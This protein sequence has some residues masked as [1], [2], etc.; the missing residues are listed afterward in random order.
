M[1]L[2]QSHFLALTHQQEQ[3]RRQLAES[4]HKLGQRLSSSLAQ[5]FGQLQVSA[6]E[7]RTP[8]TIIKGFTQVLRTNPS[9]AE[10]GDA[11]EMMAGSLSRVGRLHEVVTGRQAGGGQPPGVGHHRRGQHLA[12]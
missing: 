8:L 7:L 9:L 1:L 5:H 11:H 6:H 4:L 12:V 10:D 2:A 3:N